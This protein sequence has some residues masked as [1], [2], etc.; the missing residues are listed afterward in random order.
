MPSV[1]SEFQ[2]CNVPAYATVAAAVTGLAAPVGAVNATITVRDLASEL[3]VVN[4]ALAT[5]NAQLAAEKAAHAAT[6]AAA[7]AAAAKAL[8][9]A[10]AAKAAADLAKATYK[11]EYNALA[12]KWNAKNPKAKVA[13]KK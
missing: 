3:A 1:T 10:T 2:T 9:D 12:K 8:T 4:A 5:A 13:L 6:K 7:D 11:A